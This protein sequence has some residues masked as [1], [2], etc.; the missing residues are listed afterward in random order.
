VLALGANE[1]FSRDRLVD[2]LWG[3]QPPKSAVQSLQVYV[4]GL[5]QALGAERIE[6]RGTGYRLRV[7]AREFDLA[8]FRRL[9]DRGAQGLA[10]GRPADAAEDLRSA[11]ALWRGSP[12]ADLGGEPVFEAESERLQEER[13]RAVELLNDAQLALGR[14]EPLVPEVERLIE[15]E[16]YRERFRAQYVLAL[17]RAGR[18]KDALEAYRRARDELVEELGVD[19]SPEL[20]ELERQILRHDP[21]LAG[22]APQ[23]PAPTRLPTPPTALVGRNLEVVAVAALLRR[24][25]VRLLTLTGPGGAGKT[26]LALA[27]AEELAPELS[28]G[29][30]FVDLAPV[31]D[32]ALLGPA[33]A[34]ALEVAEGSLP[35]AA[36]EEHLRERRMLLLLDN[37]EQ[38]V[39]N[40]TLVSKLLAAAPRL[41]VLATSRSPLR[42]AAEHEYPVPPLSVPARASFE[43]L[44]ASDAVRLFAA[45]ARAV[46][47]A[48]ELNEANVEAIRH[49]CE[50]L[51]GLPLAIELAAARTKLLPPE[52][53]SERLDRSLELLTDGP[54][55]APA[56]QQTLRSTLEWSNELLSD[57]ERAVFRRLAVFSGSWELGAAE[58]VCG[59]DGAGVVGTLSS[60]VDENLVRRLARPGA[61]R[62]F[63]MLE[64]IREFAAEL[65]ARAG[66]REAFRDRHA[67]HF[68]TFAEATSEA[69]F[70]GDETAFAR[71][72]DEQ[73]NLRAALDWFEESGD[74]ESEVRLLTALWNYFSVSGHLVEAR[75]RFESVIARTAEAPPRVR[76]L[77]RVHGATF[78]FRQGDTER[79]KELWEEALV[80]FRALGDVGEIGRCVGSLGNVAIAEN[81]LDR[82]VE[83]YE[84]A[85]ALAREV[86]N[87]LRLATILGNLGLIAGLRDDAETSAR[88]ATEA[89]AL[90]RALRDHDGLAVS[91]HNLGRAQLALGRLEDARDSLTESLMT[92]RRLNYRE[93][94]AYCLSG[95]A[96]LAVTE[97][98][99]ERAAELLGASQGLFREI[100][101]A[102][103]GGEAEA[104]ERVMAQLYETLGS[105]R[106]DELRAVGAGR[107]VDELVAA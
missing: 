23:A 47:P 36:L 29:A 106:T 24:E 84:E 86:G 81:D 37:L 64:T 97:R 62:R 105:E 93:V 67:R 40:T 85:A 20:Q 33:I 101:V 55:D 98:E 77:A 95:M 58:A 30:T 82:A 44:T 68:L 69:Q 18:Q 27:V 22:P 60:L 90:Q 50:R 83:L 13:L 76:A 21:A 3:S 71:F 63:A 89:V 35:D 9:S 28:D 4:H 1:V 19:P 70:G 73:P 107:D 42:L 16:P 34:Q 104:Q 43:E 54:H 39:P 26:R 41:I 25:D 38:L 103:D 79:A 87:E 75:R 5:R 66:E 102:L 15:A 61:D 6:T 10:A 59:D 100:G 91:L 92:A 78:A 96:E 74:T 45:R 80:L 32:P 12:L 48:F 99:S 57:A 65:L 51:D 17:Y 53:L 88:Y 49:V 52:T 11:L 7:E 72:D 46:D 14:H 2:A 56:R 31:R 8:R 94:I